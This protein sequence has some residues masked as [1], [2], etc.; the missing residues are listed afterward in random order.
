MSSYFVLYPGPLFY[1]DRHLLWLQNDNDIIMSD[2]D[3]QY[4]AIIRAM[5]LNGIQTFSVRDPYSHPKP[6]GIVIMYIFH[7]FINATH[8]FLPK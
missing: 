4:P 1:V 7:L 8:C 6:K 2:M 5:N 3:G